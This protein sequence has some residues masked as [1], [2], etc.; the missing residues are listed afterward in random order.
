MKIYPFHTSTMQ[1][2]PSFIRKAVDLP[3][4]YVYFVKKTTTKK[5]SIAFLVAKKTTF[6]FFFFLIQ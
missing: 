1:P 2:D 6:F 5:L 3:A 4:V